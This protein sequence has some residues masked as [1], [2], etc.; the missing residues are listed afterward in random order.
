MNN[1]NED[2]E[3]NNGMDNEQNDNESFDNNLVVLDPDHP[4]MA[5][6]QKRLKEQLYNREQKVT[7]ELR[8]AKYLTENAKKEREEAGVELYG[9]QQELAKHQMLLEREH[10][11]YNETHQNRKLIEN[12]LDDTRNGY[13]KYQINVDEEL[14]KV[15][16]LQQER[17]NL[18][19]RI[20]YMN[21][22]KDD[23]RGDIAVIRRATEKA[24]VDKNKF[25]MDKQHQDM[26]VNRIEDKVIKLNEDIALYESQY[27]NQCKINLKANIFDSF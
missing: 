12:D 19:L 7:M 20:F 23:I 18:K 24:D 3:I 1:Q 25:E 5:R 22:A 11:R 21:N 10:D 26:I 4:L 8:E 17:D 13:R 27:H 14:K 9:L 2:N 15:R 6:F 16:D